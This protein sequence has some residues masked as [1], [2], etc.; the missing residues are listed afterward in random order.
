MIYASINSKLQY[1][2]SAQASRAL[3][4][5][6]F[7]SFKIPP[8]RAT[9]VFKCPTQGSDFKVRFFFLQGKNSDRDF[10]PIRQTLK[11]RPCRPFSEP[12]TR[13][14]ELFTFKRLYFK[15]KH[16]FLLDRLGTFGPNS[17][18]QPA[19]G[20]MPVSCSGGFWSFELICALHCNGFPWSTSQN[21]NWTTHV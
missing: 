10:L 6:Y 21:K 4:S 5:V 19:K 15:V 9:I 17:P 1:P 7:G 11:P 16:V 14:G 20:Q 2:L 18:P 3:E 12:F 8:L 13:E